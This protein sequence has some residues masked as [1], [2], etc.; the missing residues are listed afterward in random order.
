MCNF[1]SIKA[2][3]S[4]SKNYPKSVM[5][6]FFILSLFFLFNF[7]SFIYSQFYS[8][9]R[10]NIV[11]E[12]KRNLDDNLTLNDSGTSID[13]K[14]VKGSPYAKNSFSQGKIYNKKLGTSY[15]YFLRYNVYNDI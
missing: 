6:N 4:T 5:K 3:Y 8:N 1:N 12:S 14:G 7:N 9:N 10:D 13:L 2:Y 15:S 11:L